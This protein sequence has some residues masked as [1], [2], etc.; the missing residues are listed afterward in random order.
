[1]ETT[2]PET[3]TSPATIYQETYRRPK[4]GRRVG[5]IAALASAA[6]F[7]A[8]CGGSGEAKSSST[9]SRPES[10]TTP[11]ATV[12]TSVKVSRNTAAPKPADSM[13]TNNHLKVELGQENHGAGSEFVPVR[14]VNLGEKACWMSIRI[15]S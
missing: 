2:T 7:A 12:V 10:Q 4:R 15:S 11:P 5:Y 14:F 8:G 1:M 13:C 3:N 9:A 6:A